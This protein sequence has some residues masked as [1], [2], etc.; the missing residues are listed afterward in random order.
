MARNQNGVQT[1][2]AQARALL[3][4]MGSTTPFLDVIFRCDSDRMLNGSPVW[5]GVDEALFF[6]RSID[7]EMVNK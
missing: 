6:Y 1:A 4:E 3:L 5:E 7:D 2:V